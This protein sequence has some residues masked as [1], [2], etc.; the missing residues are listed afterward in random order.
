MIEWQMGVKRLPSREWLGARRKYPWH[1]MPV[2]ASFPASQGMS[3]RDVGALA[4]V[5]NQRYA[6]KRFKAGRDADG[7]LRIW[8][9]A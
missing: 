7:A 2:G 3:L 1:D 5:A 6:P 8:R 4:R 9:E